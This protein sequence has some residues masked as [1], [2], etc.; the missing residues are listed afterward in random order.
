MTRRARTQPGD[1]QLAVAYLRVSTEDQ[2]LGPEAQR[3]A[4]EAF[5]GV[6]KTDC[7]AY[8]VE[9][10]SGAT[11]PEARP[12]VL[13]A[14]ARV[15]ASRAG[16]LVVA[17]RDR[18]ARDVPGAA[19]A[20]RL[21]REAGA[22]VLSADGMGNGDD[23]ASRLMATIADGFAEYER[24][25]IAGRTRAALAVKR[26]RGERVGAVPYGYRL[27]AD[28]VHLEP[29]EAEQALVARARELR[30]EGLPLREVGRILFEEGYASRR[31]RPLHPQQV[32]RILQTNQHCPRAC[33][34]F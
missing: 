24:A 12:G 26:S 11:P 34:A 14:L 27:A 6:R 2:H 30:G 25:L 16:V 22:R 31:A 15:R 9:H 29:V 17:K 20:E 21:F 4:I 33:P 5:L 8:V 32:A 10:V 23:P 18:L 7:V 28:G 3:V 1:P 13:E 19:A